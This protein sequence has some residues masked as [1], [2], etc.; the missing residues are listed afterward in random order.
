[1]EFGET[2]TI[3]NGMDSDHESVREILDMGIQRTKNALDYIKDIQYSEVQY[4]KS[5]VIDPL[6]RFQMAGY[7]FTA[8][9]EGLKTVRELFKCHKEHVPYDITLDYIQQIIKRYA[10]Q[11][12]RDDYDGDSYD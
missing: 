1:M 11:Q 5:P 10:E 8:E 2:V 7:Y 4:V 6:A 12:E 3:P 9:S